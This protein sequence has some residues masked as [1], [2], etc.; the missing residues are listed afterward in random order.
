MGREAT[1]YSI[2]QALGCRGSRKYN[3]G[4]SKHYSEKETYE[5]LK[6]K[7]SVF[8]PRHL[9]VVLIFSCYVADQHSVNL[10]EVLKFSPE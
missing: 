2:G 8:Q 4:Q 7:V 10:E 1:F 3:K 9:T 5:G 6:L